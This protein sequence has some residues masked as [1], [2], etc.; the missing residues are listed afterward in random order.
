MGLSTD[1]I[2][3]DLSDAVTISLFVII[4]FCLGFSC[5]VAGN[6]LGKTQVRMELYEVCQTGEDF[7]I[8]GKNGV[9]VCSESEN[10][11]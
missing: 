9:Y 1:Q 4:S 2:N 7:T 6:Y 5:F 8:T 11:E 10:Y 3:L